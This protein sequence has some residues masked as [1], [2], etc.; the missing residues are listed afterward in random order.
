MKHIKTFFLSVLLIF[1]AHFTFSQ[2]ASAVSG[3]N[4][5]IKTTIIDLADAQYAN[6]SL[7]DV[8]AKYKGKVIYLDFWASWCNPCRKEMPYSL[9]LQ[10]KYAGKDVV[11]L[12]MSTD[13]NAQAWQD[14]VAQLKLTG[15]NYRASDA[16]KQQIYNQFNLQYIPRYV[17]IDKNGKV[18]DGNAKRPSDP[19][20][21]A[22]INKLL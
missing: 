14:M 16:V 11:F 19:A 15:M 1:I 6:T 2:Q 12:Y 22:D 5:E 13:K 7:N 20:A 21:V 3:S 9:E 18:V 4:S 17:L 10:K 8:F